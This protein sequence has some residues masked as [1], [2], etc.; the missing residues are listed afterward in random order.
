MFRFDSRYTDVINKKGFVK[1]IPRMTKDEVIKILR[2]D[3][4]MP[5]NQ[6]VRVVNEPEVLATFLEVELIEE[7]QSDTAA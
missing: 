7:G 4:K 3:Y 2:N 1:V 5:Y 6:A